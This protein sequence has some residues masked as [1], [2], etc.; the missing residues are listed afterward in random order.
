MLTEQQSPEQEAAEAAAFEAGFH[1]ERGENVPA[2][3]V[4]TD[5]PSAR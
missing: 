3:A 2:P 4:V 5:P 1:E